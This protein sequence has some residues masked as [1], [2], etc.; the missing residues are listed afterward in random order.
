MP[1]CQVGGVINLQEIPTL[2]AWVSDI[3]SQRAVSKVGHLLMPNIKQ[4]LAERWKPREEKG[5]RL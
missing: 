1:G 5:D 2:G 3:V 4:S